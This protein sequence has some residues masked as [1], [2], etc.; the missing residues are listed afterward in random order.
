MNEFYEELKE[1]AEKRNYTNGKEGETRS[2]K[3]VAG[4]DV[5]VTRL[6]NW[7]YYCSDHNSVGH[8]LITSGDGHCLA[9]LQK[10][11]E[12]IAKHKESRGDTDP[13]WTNF[14]AHYEWKDIPFEVIYSWWNEDLGPDQKP[15]EVP[16]ENNICSYDHGFIYAI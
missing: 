1:R 13:L 16:N 2:G 11:I 15:Y 10:H 5:T 6:G 4:N 9:S 14:Y 8:Y 12:L 7:L 3:T